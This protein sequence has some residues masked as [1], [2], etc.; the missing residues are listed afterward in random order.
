MAAPANAPTDWTQ[1][2][3]A[4]LMRD[5][6]KTAVMAL[7]LLVAVIVAARQVSRSADPASATAAGPTAPEGGVSE[8][9]APA[10]LWG[11]PGAAGPPSRETRPPAGARTITRDLFAMKVSDFP[12]DQEVKVAAPPTT[13]TA[14]AA[15]PEEIEAQQ[16]RAQAQDLALQST[17]I[18]SQPTA[19]VNG[20]V[21]RVGDRLRGFQVVEITQGACVLV[22]KGVRVTLGMNNR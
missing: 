20:Q 22:Q 2:L 16:I 14:P 19:I 13:S 18:S 4:E 9:P 5:K 8:P 1:R 17:Y 6:R 21:V 7:L 3:K 15:S 10:A 11:V 12:V